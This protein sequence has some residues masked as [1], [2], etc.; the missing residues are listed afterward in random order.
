MIHNSF[1]TPIDRFKALAVFKLLYQRNPRLPQQ[2][3]PIL[4][5][6]APHG[7]GINTLMNLLQK[8]S[9]PALPHASLDFAKMDPSTTLNDMLQSIS[10][11]LGQ[12]GNGQGGRLRFPRYHL[13]LSIISEALSDNNVGK[14]RNEIKKL[15]VRSSV[16]EKIDDLITTTSNQWFF[17]TFLLVIVKWILPVILH[18]TPNSAARWYGTHKA[19]LNMSFTSDEIDVLARFRIWSRPGNLAEQLQVI[20]RLL[21]EAFLE[22]M[23][24]AF[25]RK[26]DSR[27]RERTANIALFLLNYDSLS[28]NEAGKLF[29]SML[30]KQRSEGKT[31]PLLL[32]MGSHQRLF[33]LTDLSQ[34]PPFQE[35]KEYK[36]EQ[37]NEAYAQSLYERWQKELSHTK[38]DSQPQM[39]LP[40]WLHDFGPDA[41]SSLLRMA[42]GGQTGVFEDTML[43]SKLHHLTSGHPLSLSLAA[44]VLQT[45]SS[46]GRKLSP[47]ELFQEKL[48]AGFD[49]A[50]TRSDTSVG[51]YLLHQFLQQITEQEREQLIFCAAPRTL[52]ADALRVVLA[53]DSDGEAER[54]VDQYRRYT[55]ARSLDMPDH[56]IR[57]HPLLRDLLMQQLIARSTVRKHYYR[58]VHTNLLEHFADLASNGDKQARCEEVYHA[59]ALGDAGPATVAIRAAVEKKD[60]FWRSLLEA[61]AQAPHEFM[62]SNTYERA[63]EALYRAKLSGHIGDVITSLVLHTW[64]ISSAK[65]AGKY[66]FT[67]LSYGLAETYRYLARYEVVSSSE[68]T[69]YYLKP[70]R[71]IASRPEGETV[72]PGSYLPDLTPFSTRKVG[73]FWQRARVIAALLLLLTL[74]ISYP[75]IYFRAYVDTYCKPVGIT[76]VPAVLKTV[77]FSNGLSVSHA[78]D[79]ECIGISDG[80]FAFDTQTNPESGAY[81]VRAAEALAAGDT[82]Q[83]NALLTRASQVDTSDAE[84]LIYKENQHVLELSRSQ[85]FPYVTVVLLTMLT[86][87]ATDQKSIATG[88][89]DLQGAYIAQMEHNRDFRLPLL[90]LL[91]ANAG[92]NEQYAPEVTKQIIQAAQADPTIVAVNGPPQSRDQGMLAIKMLAAAHIPVVSSTISSD[93]F[94]GLSPYFF[95]VAPANKYQVAMGVKY[96]EQVLHAKTA[97]LFEALNDNY[98]QSLAADFREQFQ[99]KDHNKIVQTETYDANDINSSNTIHDKAGHACSYNPDLIYFTGRSDG[100]IR[101]LDNLN[102]CGKDNTVR[103]MGADTLYQLATAPNSGYPPYAYNRLYYTSFAFPQEWELSG[104][105]LFRPT[106]FDDY[107]RYF[108]PDH[109]YA[110]SPV[111]GHTLANGHVIL[112]YDA[113]LTLLSAIQDTVKDT[114]M[115]P[116]KLESLQA[117]LSSIH[118]SKAIQGASGCIDFGSAPDGDPV[119]KTIVML[120][121]DEHGDTEL[122]PQGIIG[123]LK[124]QG[125]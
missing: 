39:Y 94:T 97:V 90:R 119:N 28:A 73:R 83:A 123:C 42:D 82:E 27:A 15:V 11:Q 116:F 96:A 66:N 9:V 7:G 19:D 76:S 103:I 99:D 104:L 113:L 48:P 61:V 22:D 63:N 115:L 71:S 47:E 80:R 86:A 46:H 106:F 3:L 58:V 117:H 93:S 10:L 121:V 108:D 72:L 85:H 20:E 44:F 60:E 79:G 24:T 67:D 14:L 114:K 102:P 78:S 1:N 12:P 36:T 118:G 109:R 21:L 62:P 101:L 2:M 92:G 35:E 29:L 89:D 30:V 45:A 13:G 65:S 120:H 52:S 125:R 6:L 54:I 68:V 59:L 34:N 26:K 53:L 87:R 98:S 74:F 49:R 25:N 37:E 57:F 64:L 50:F 32:V 18:L 122:V 70:A 51:D 77:Y 75:L 55:F 124:I 4:L 40:V 112:E 23:R 107:P 5:F 111:Y 100:M 110:A 17:I 81:K 88:R 8:K 33:D 16:L 43:T 31:D 95:H 91:V 84:A 105:K 38:Y 69:D 56:P 41:A